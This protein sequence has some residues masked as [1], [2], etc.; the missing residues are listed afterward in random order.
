VRRLI[1]N[2]YVQLIFGLI[3]SS[4]GYFGTFLSALTLLIKYTGFELN[5][6]VYGSGRTP[7]TFA[8]FVITAI[9]ALVLPS[10]VWKILI[11]YGNLNSLGARAKRISRIL[12]VFLPIWF[13][14]VFLFG[15]LVF[16]QILV[17]LSHL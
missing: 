6:R 10:I 4:V 12:F 7:I 17:T 5:D 11:K 3:L 14:P 8:L 15:S 9:F 1:S 16:R 2:A 13:F